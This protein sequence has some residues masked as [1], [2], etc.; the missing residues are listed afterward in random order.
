MNIENMEAFVYIN[1]YGSFN[2]AAE[3]LF[4]SQPSVTA[5]IQS[6][7]RELGCKL[8][9]RLGRQILL[10]E[11]GRRFLPYAQQMLQVLQ[12]GR[13]QIQTV[14]TTPE[15]LTIGC[16]L[17]VSH[18]ILP[19]L[20][21]RLKK[22]YPATRFKVVT[23]ATDQLVSR[24][25]NKELDMAFVRKV[26]NPSIRTVSS[27]EDPISLYVYADHP[28][29]SHPP[30]SAA[31]LQG[32]PLVFFECGSLDWLRI[33]RV[34][35]SL[36]VPPDIAFQVDH[37]ETARKLVLQ[38]ASISLLPGLSVQE[39]VQSGRLVRIPLPELEGISLQTSLV[40]LKES[41]LHIAS[42]TAEM[43]RELEYFRPSGIL[44][45]PVHF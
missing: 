19:A 32:E 8:F 17:S 44:Q 11:E 1:H 5:R 7:E 38:Q 4:L 35:E 3:I 40:T 20:F 16:T 23:A 41:Q 30:G 15:E 2:K 22:Q 36:P 27:Y 13:Q 18:Y 9:E 33:H 43:L 45:E 24:L 21:P 28:F 14:R 37:A 31:A 29:A 6:L 39:D 25:L 12:K 26:M 42:V 34:F 10:T